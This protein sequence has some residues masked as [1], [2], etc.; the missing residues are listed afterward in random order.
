M[1][2]LWIF[3]FWNWSTLPCNH[4]NEVDTMM[5]GIISKHKSIMLHMSFM[6]VVALVVHIIECGTMILTYFSPT[7]IV[8]RCVL[9]KIEYGWNGI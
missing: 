2:F 8:V 5:V 7:R 6:F 4:P 9:L 1:N 3:F